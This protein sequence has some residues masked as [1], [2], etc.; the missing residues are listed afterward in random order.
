[1]RKLLVA[2]ALVV[3]ATSVAG[4]Q[5]LD[6]GG[7]GKADGTTVGYIIQ[8]FGL[9]TVLSVAP[10]LL[11]MVTSFTR[12]VIAFSILRAGIGLQSTPANL[13]LISLSLFMTFYVMAPTFDQAW[14]TGVK[15]LMDNQ[16]SQT[17]AFEKI[18]DPFRTF[19]LHNVRD[20]DFDLFADL[21]RER[22]Q[23]V[24]RDTID[25]RI[26]VPAFMISEIRRGFEIGF[27][28]VLP[29]LVIDLIVATITMAMGMM[30]LPPTVVS[31]PFKILFFVLIDGW[32]LLVGSLVRSFT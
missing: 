6:L 29:F 24:S 3:A 28:I 10:G 25:L 8:M 26:L 11:I 17:E 1:M 30:M 13:I 9:L 18:S 21:A 31:L 14:N 22:G 2:T 7:I 32:N 5:Q 23:A 12:F 15:P 27:L 16:I 4:A 19:M 20:K